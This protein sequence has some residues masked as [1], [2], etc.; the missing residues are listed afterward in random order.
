[1][2]LFFFSL[3]VTVFG[4]AGVAQFTKLSLLVGFF[5]DYGLIIADVEH[6]VSTSRW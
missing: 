2:R 1:L 6:H 4:V 5:L 3:P